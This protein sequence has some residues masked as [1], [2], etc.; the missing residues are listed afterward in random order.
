MSVSEV[1]E[2]CTGAA[3]SSVSCVSRRLVRLKE[4]SCG[5]VTVTTLDTTSE[6]RGVPSGV[7]SV[8]V[9]CV[10]CGVEGADVCIISEDGT[11]NLGLV[12]DGPTESLRTGKMATG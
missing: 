8:S 9:V 11:S 12:V 2:L 7:P 5:N 10:C 1:W 4:I 3:V 6:R